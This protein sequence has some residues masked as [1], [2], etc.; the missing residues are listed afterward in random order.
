MRRVGGCRRPGDT[1]SHGHPEGTGGGRA[2]EGQGFGVRAIQDQ[3]LGHCHH[4]GCG[5]NVSKMREKRRANSPGPCPSG[6]A[7]A[8]W[9][10]TLGRREP[11]S[12]QEPA[13]SG[14]GDGVGGG[15][16][17]GPPGRLVGLLC[18]GRKMLQGDL[19]STFSGRQVWRLGWSLGAGSAGALRSDEQ[20]G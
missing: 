10:W 9:A 13:Q 14:T 8:S 20:A 4:A 2:G 11:R 7:G 12:P 3:L 18:K 16:R 5:Q 19:K 6:T 1:R 17:R 15:H